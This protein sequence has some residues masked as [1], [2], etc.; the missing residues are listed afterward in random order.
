MKN[1]LHTIICVV[2]LAV[3]QL[4]YAQSNDPELITEKEAL[5]FL[6]QYMAL[7][8][9]TDYSRD[10]YKQHVRISLRAREEMP[11]GKV[12]PKREFMHFVLPVRVNNENLDNFRPEMYETLKNRVKGMTIEEAALEV[13]HW[14]HEHVTYQ[15][16][17]AR[18]S[19][20]LASMRSAIGR[21]GEES[22]FTVA[23][24]RTIGI[25]ARQVYTPRW[26]HT[27]DNHAW[28]E[29]WIDGTWKFLGAC[30]PEPVLNLGWFNAPASR[31]MLMHTKAFGHYEGPERVMTETPCYTEIDVT[32]NYAP[33]SILKVR[34]VDT[35]GKPVKAT[36]QFRLYNYAEF[37]P[38]STVPTNERGECD[39]KAGRGTLLVWATDNTRYGYKLVDLGQE[40]ETTIV[41]Q[42]C[43]PDKPISLDVIPP[44]ERN[45]VPPMTEEQV[46][47][48]KQ[49]LAYED[50]LRGAY[51]STFY[52]GNNPEYLVK[53][54]G[55]HKTI[56]EF[57][58][59]SKD[60]EKALHLL[61]L[62]SD[63]DLRDV[64]F[65]VLIDHYK[66]T[67]NTK[68]PRLLNPRVSNEQLT[69]YR[70]QLLKL[71]P[72]NLST[73]FREDPWQLEKWCNE[74]III[75]E[76]H[77][78]QQLC[79][80]PVSV[81]RTQRCDRHSRD[82]FF[83]STAR[84]LGI[85]SYLDEVTN[86]VMWHN[87]KNGE[88]IRAFQ[89]KDTDSPA[90]SHNS[91][92]LHLHYTPTAILSNPRYYNHFTLS[93]IVDGL[94]QLLNYPEDATWQTTFAK[95]VYLD[96]GDYILTTGTRLASGNVLAQMTFFH[97]TGGE[98]TNVEL[99]MRESTDEVQV[100][101]GFGSETR[102]TPI[103]IQANDGVSIAGSTPTSFTSA[104]LL[105]EK[106]LLATTGRGYYVIGLLSAGTEPTNHALNDLS[107]VRSE[108]EQ[109]GRPIMLIVSD[110]D[111]AA[112]IQQAF[113]NL[114]ST[115]HW[116]IDSTGKIREGM[117]H[118]VQ[119]TPATSLPVFL[120]AD[121]FDRVVFLR[122]GYTIG[123]G[124]QLMKVVRKL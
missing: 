97:L 46:V 14:C 121:T 65:D 67:P 31:A 53:S 99:T 4:L 50:S 108:L 55:N 9:S 96:E 44:S 117:E 85:P 73:L 12:V 66:N 11:W 89:N 6:Y 75:D 41:L 32:D 30:E 33:T 92:L 81:W 58:E 39:F 119:A 59:T 113:P 114:P 45:T 98:T 111:E 70:S 5:S 52:T 83:V 40:V 62:I 8:D 94:P 35:Q 25:P 105:P 34:V 104:D 3:G 101:G 27:D 120:I 69:P 78:P 63:K 51:T 95:G 116:G 80:N 56:K 2:L 13:N 18:T 86:V 24:L 106:S 64:P 37:Y 72:K 68:E 124:D 90:N 110:Q 118:A 48:N 122:Q 57:L 20:P 16:S 7:P 87:D 82:I 88:W 107:A 100:I 38:L 29:A 91:G 61:S 43:S 49:R 22:T 84:T 21:C 77:N 19:S 26:A 71:I 17:D 10:F 74:H 115:V 42:T 103:I 109:W 93:K 54:R 47:R 123:L 60:Q 1:R 112:R 15:P 28:V 23:A 79:M 36:V 76:L 102:Y